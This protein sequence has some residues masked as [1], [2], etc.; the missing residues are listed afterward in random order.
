MLQTI[1]RQ[2]IIQQTNNILKSYNIDNKK[3]LNNK[4]LINI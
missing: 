4:Y 2:K 3:E 1:N